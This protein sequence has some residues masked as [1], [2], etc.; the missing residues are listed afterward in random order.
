MTIKKFI[1]KYETKY[2]AEDQC[3]VVGS[4]NVW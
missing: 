1:L 4:R 3:A 2:V